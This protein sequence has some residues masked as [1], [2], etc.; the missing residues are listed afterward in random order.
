MLNSDAPNASSTAE[1]A[2]ALGS[3]NVTDVMRKTIANLPVFSRAHSASNFCNSGIS[4]PPGFEVKKITVCDN[5]T[6]RLS[7]IVLVAALIT[8]SA[9]E[10]MAREAIRLTAR[11]LFS[12]HP[13]GLALQYSAQFLPPLE[14]SGFHR[15]DRHAHHS[16]GFLRGTLSNISQLDCRSCSRGQL[17]HSSG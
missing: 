14:H 12:G 3:W 7:P 1:R 2:P 13:G 10:L 15:C 8:E 16:S 5:S 4:P 17:I 6:L 9:D 11:A